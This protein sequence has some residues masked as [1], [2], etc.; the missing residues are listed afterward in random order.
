MYYSAIGVVATLVLLVVNQDILVTSKK[1]FD[2]PAWI[3][4]RRFLFAVLAYYVID[5]LWGMLE[6][7]KLSGLLFADTTVYFVAMSV[8]LW[9]WAEFTVAY[10]EEKNRFGKLLTITG[11][12][13]SVAIT[14]IVVINIFTPILF[15][16][17]KECVYNALPFRYVILS[18]QIIIFILISIY[19][20]LYL[21]RHK[22][23]RGKSGRYRIIASFGISMATMLFLQLWFPLLP[24]YAIGY[25]LGTCLLHS[26]V[27]NDEKEERK[28]GI[29]ETKKITEL[30]DRFVSLIDNMP[31]MA[32]TKDAETG[33]YLACNQRF[34]EY[35]NKPDPDSVIGLNDYQIFDEETAAHFIKDDKVALSLTKPYIFYED[36]QD[37]TGAKRQLQT[38][39]LKYTDISGRLCVLG[40]CQDVTDIVRIQHEN[41]MTKEAYEKAVNSGLIYT[42]MVQT[43]ARDY[44]DMFYINTDTEEYVEYRNGEEKS[45]LEEIRRGWHFFSDCKK[46]LAENVFNDDRDSFLNAMNR[47]KLMKALEKKDTFVMT[48]RR[49]SGNGPVYVNMKISRM[50]DE[51]YIIIGFTDVDAE[52]R[53][54]MAKNEALAQALASAENA[55][56]AKNLFLSGMSHE[57]RTPINAI[58]GLEKLALKNNGLDD[59]TRRYIEKMG[60]SADQLL[61]IINDILDISRIE[62]GRTIVHRDEFS[63]KSLIAQ[64]SA[65]FKSKCNQKGIKYECRVIGQLDDT[66]IGDYSKI[67]DVMLNIL[68]N[69]VKFTEKSGSVTFT[70]EKTTEYEDQSIIR[71]SIKDT[72]IGIEKDYLPKLFDA[73]SRED[74]NDR[75]KFGSSGLGLAITKRLI[76]L[77][78]GSISVE[79]RKGV[80]TEV[81]VM[82]PLGNSSGNEFGI[83]GSIDLSAVYVLVVDDDPIE[84]EH[85]RMV[86]EECGIKADFCTNGPDALQRLEVQYGKEDPYNF[87]LMDWNMPGMSGAETASEIFRIYGRECTVV[88]MTAYSWEDISVEAEESGVYNYISKPLFAATVVENFER[89]ARRS[90]LNIFKDKKLIDLSGKTLL[91]AEDIE[92][93]AEIITDTLDLENI[94]VEHA[95]NGRI[96]LEMFENSVP[97]KY[98]AILM[99][100][101]MP[102][103]DGFE[104]TKAIRALSREDA[105]TIPIIALTANAFDDD[106]HRSIASGMN[107]HMTKPIDTDLLI[108][109]LSDIMN[110]NEE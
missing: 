54:T 5:I 96:A 29:E 65:D 83:K 109:V 62:S 94:K 40:M 43:L 56:R 22:G 17:D 74:N 45:T 1:S 11:R 19:A 26:F 10:L 46:E 91:L 39:K 15:T 9:L 79:S 30:R 33:V 23:G 57:I 64:I 47:K 60:E 68:S 106:A 69:A 32:F 4:Y 87:V 59:E 95:A 42:Q 75:A 88:A 53:E 16:V 13:L 77:M 66:Y 101:R 98:T 71:F 51:K 38:T 100:I 28:R 90:K 99:D 55:N 34:A 8:G 80:G 70:V 72:G 49:L 85:A 44:I 41:A 92:L 12:A 104:A 61:S 36:V 73:F 63:L 31:G 58:I 89:I 82:L 110:G 103:M 3:V 48:Y 52:M 18:I 97:G 21:Y 81:T 108:H 86:L 7:N 105:K 6:A 24:L 2:K 14:A 25:L 84:A 35:A 102:E 50:P 76:E 27:A 67:K 107:A 93:N 37:A 20:I 78:N